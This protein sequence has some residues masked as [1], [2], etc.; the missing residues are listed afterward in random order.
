MPP[1]GRLLTAMVTPFRADGSVDFDQAGK[2]AKNL[3]ESG[4]DGLVVTGTTGE[5]PVLTPEE[6]LGMYRAVREAVG[7]S[8]QL[9]AGTTNYSTAESIEASHAAMPYADGFLLTVPYYNK[10]PQEG[11]YRHFRA[12]AEAVNGKPCLLYNV[13]SRTVTNMTAATTLRLARDVPNIVGV[14]EASANP[15]Q[16]GA[17]IAGAPDHFSVWSG[18]DT[19]TFWI[20]AMGGYGIVSVAAHLVGGQ[21]KE[22]INHMASGNTAAAAR[23]HH[24]LMPLVNAMFTTS[25]PIPLKASLNHLGFNV[26]IPRLPLIDL[27][28]KQREAL[29]GVLAG[30]QCDPYLSRRAVAV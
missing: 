2:L 15:E 5:S 18:N 26:G 16:V 28:E 12:I 9:I 3:V 23:L 20:M 30:Y 8:A 24:H 19:D 11:L 27:D 1:F 21:I 6:R 7:S 4:T 25:N 17:I 13:P 14:K 22:M 10:P 29:K